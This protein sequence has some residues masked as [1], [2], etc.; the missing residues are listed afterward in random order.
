MARGV[1]ATRPRGK[2]P[3]QSN[4]LRIVGGVHGGRK[5]RFPDAPGLRPT[6]DRVR[7]TLFNWL[8]P[9]IQGARCLDLFAGSGALGF[10]AAS[11]GAG[12]V[13]GV[14]MNPKVARQLREN[15]GLLKLRQWQLVQAD[16]LKWLA[17]TPV[18]P[19]DVVFL[20]P[21]F[22][23]DLMLQSVQLLEQHGWLTDQ[24]LVYLEMDAADTLPVLPETWHKLR[25]KRAGQVAYSLYRR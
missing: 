13:I 3:G 16:A 23:E 10:E 11:R 7:E 4:Q 18:S 15:A 1:D 5:L 21:P 17:D 6:S 12:E 22:A 25:E 9:V 14:E 19:F 20:D 8:Q 24:A 2:R